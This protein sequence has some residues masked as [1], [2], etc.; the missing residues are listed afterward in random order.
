[1][2][3][4]GGWMGLILSPNCYVKT[5]SK[6][7]QEAQQGQHTQGNEP[8][9]GSTKNRPTAQE[10]TARRDEARGEQGSSKAARR[11]DGD[12]GQ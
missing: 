9:Q 6:Q 7:G 11:T 4:L 12:R 3:A 5:E 8:K 1:M 2:G 10:G